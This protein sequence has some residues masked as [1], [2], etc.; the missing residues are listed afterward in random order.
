MLLIVEDDLAFARILLDAGPREGL[1][2]PGRRA[3]RGRPG[4]GPR[5]EADAITLDISL[6]D[7]DGWRVLDRLK[8]D[9]ATRHIPVHII[10]VADEP[11]RAL[12]QGALGFLHKPADQ[13]RA[14][15]GL[16]HAC[17]SSS[18][19]GSRSLLVV[20]DDEV[21]RHSILEL[22]GNGDVQHGGGGHAAQE[23]LEALA[24]EHFDCMVLDLLL[25]DMTGLELLEQIKKQPQLRVAAHHRLHRQGP[26]QARRR[27]QL[28]AP[29]PDH[30]RQG[31]ALAERLLDET[32][33]FLHRERGQPARAQAPDAGEAAPARTRCWPGK[34]VLVVDDDVRNIFAMTSVLERHKME[35]LPAENGQDALE[36]LEKN[37]GGRRRADGHHDAGDGRLRDHARASARCRAFKDLPIIALTAKAMKGDR[38]KC[39]EAGASDYIAKPV[40]T[41][42]L[43]SLLRVWLYR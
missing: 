33:L 43:L 32:A 19:G 30:H 38:E 12:Q 4:P 10:S 7:I 21:Q 35:V 6:P 34:K 3:R 42:Q 22:I 36:L 5:A 16:R 24:R 27:P 26:L 8:D 20:E 37:A 29:G 9:P 40:D 2:G 1:Q 11:E 41:E 28:Q 17:A 18:T 31:R 39:L 14:G 15:R 13:G 23:A 25:P